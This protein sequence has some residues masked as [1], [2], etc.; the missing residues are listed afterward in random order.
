MLHSAMQFPLKLTI[1]V[2]LLKH[3]FDQMETNLKKLKEF[4]F[5]EMEK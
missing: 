3:V 1:L 2:V 4:F 5:Q